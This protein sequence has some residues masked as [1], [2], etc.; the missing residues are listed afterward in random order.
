MSE[1]IRTVVSIK[2]PFTLFAFLAV[3]LLV[4]FRTKT[5]PESVFKL[6]GEKSWERFSSLLNRSLLYGL[7]AFL[8]LCGIAVLGQVLGYMTT[9][10]AASVEEVKAELA[11]RKT[12]AP[13]AAKVAI[14]AYQ[15]GLTFAQNDKLSEA[16]ASLEASLKAVPTVT[17][18]ETLALLHHRVGNTT[19]AMELAEQAVSE[20]R[21]TGAVNTA[22]A[23]RVLNDVS[24]PRV[25]SPKGC[26]ADA[27]LVGAK[28]DLPPGGDSFETAAVLVPCVYRG[29][30]DIETTQ[31]KYYKLALQSSQTLAV[32]FRLRDSDAHFQ[33][34][35]RLHGPAGAPSSER[36]QY[37]NP[38]LLSDSIQGPGVWF[39]V[40]RFDGGSSRLGLPILASIGRHGCTSH[41]RESPAG[42]VV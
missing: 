39:C 30:I 35:L 27:G 16:I 3:I 40:C 25:V 33:N 36:K 2:D 20:S 15:K 12:D 8:V 4:A 11:L 24:A 17:A 29:L 26:P 21:D 34:S 37:F 1:L 38:V 5:V 7:A 18:R 41:R 19:R 6:I 31:W 10:R 28:L 14:D 23:E 42:C 32:V 9:A 22:R 13:D